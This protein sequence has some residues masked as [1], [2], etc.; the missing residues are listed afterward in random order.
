VYSEIKPFKKIKNVKIEQCGRGCFIRKAPQKRDIECARY[1]LEKARKTIMS[2]KY[3]LVILDEANIAV[4]LGLLRSKDIIDVLIHKPRSVELV[5]TGR[6]APRELIKCADLVTEMKEV[7]HPYQKGIK[8]R[9]G[10]EY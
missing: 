8:A 5:L 9:L 2:E 6:Y 1:A 10:I 7:K 3:G 4:K